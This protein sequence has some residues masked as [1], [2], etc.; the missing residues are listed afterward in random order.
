MV[1]SQKVIRT[2]GHT[3][4]AN[5]ASNRKVFSLDS[6]KEGFLLEQSCRSNMEATIQYYQ[7]N[8]DRFMRYLEENGQEFT[9][10]NIFRDQIKKYLL[11]LKKAKKWKDTEYIESD[12][13]LSSIS[14]QTYIRAIKA[15]ISWMEEEGYIEGPVSSGIK[16]PKVVKS[17]IE[18]LTEDEI[19]SVIKYLGDKK[20]NKL[21]DLLIVLLLL[22]CGLRIDEV[23]RLKFKNIQLSQNSLTVLGKGQKERIVSYG[24]NLQRLIYKYINQERPETS[25]QKVESLFLLSDGKPITQ[26]TVKQLFKRMKRKTGIEKLHPHLLRHTYCTMYLA[27]GGDIFSLKQSTGHESFEIL[28]NYVH[29]ASTL[30]N[31]RTKSLSL[32]DGLKIKI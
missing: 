28:N 30:I 17:V 19:K 7:G 6:M 9:T 23:T 18:I 22:E 13:V 25:T 11:Y 15:W 32:L 4:E 24:V 27:G 16:L 2:S 3:S 8:I 14:V 21:R 1:K 29:L 10:E 12:D 5:L 31:I 26:S 20:Q